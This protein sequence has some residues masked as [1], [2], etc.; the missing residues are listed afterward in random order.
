MSK[1]TKYKNLKNKLYKN[2]IIKMKGYDSIIE[3]GL[4]LYSLKK[5]NFMM[6]IKFYKMYSFTSDISIDFIFKII[7]KVFTNDI[8]INILRFYLRNDIS[9]RS[10]EDTNKN[11]LKFQQEIE[12]MP[13]AL[14]DFSIKT[15]DISSYNSIFLK[16]RKEQ[17]NIALIIFNKFK[18]LLTHTEIFDIN[19]IFK[20]DDENIDFYYQHKI[21][22]SDIAWGLLLDH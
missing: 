14:G 20:F 21:F 16:N 5:N 17:L 9:F 3:L 18:R 7:N 22:S 19:D 1:I 10:I 8:S 13:N 11:T 12:I 4:N 6:S 2:L 15:L